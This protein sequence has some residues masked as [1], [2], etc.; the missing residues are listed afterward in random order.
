MSIACAIIS[1]ILLIPLLQLGEINLPGNDF[2]REAF[3]MEDGKY[4]TFSVGDASILLSVVS[5]NSRAVI[6]LQGDIRLTH[7]LTIASGKHIIVNGN[8]H[9]I[10]EYHHPIASETVVNGMR[11]ADY[12]E[13]ID[14]K[15]A[16]TTPDGTTL[17]L[18][19]SKVFQATGWADIY[20]ESHNGQA[21]QVPHGVTCGADKPAADQDNVFLHLSIWYKRYPLLLTA[22]SSTKLSFDPTGV[23]ADG[24]ITNPDSRSRFT[25]RPYYYLSNYG[26]SPDAVTIKNHKLYFPPQYPAVA[27]CTL[28]QIVSVAAGGQ[29]ELNDV[30]LS[31]GRNYTIVNRGQLRMNGCTL[32]NPIARGIYSAGRLFLERSAFCDIRQHAVMADYESPAY[33]PYADITSCSFQRIGLYGSDASAIKTT[34]KS[35]IARNDFTDVQYASIC[36][37]RTY[38]MTADKVDACHTLAEHNRIQY[39][40]WWKGLRRQLALQDGGAIY[41]ATN[42]RQAVVRYNTIVGAGSSF[43]ETGAYYRGIFC[44]D[45]AYNMQIY[46][47]VIAH[48]EQGTDCYDIDSRDCIA[49]RRNNVP[50]GPNPRNTNNYICYNLCTGL[51][52]M[53]ELGSTSQD[54]YVP[55][56]S[57]TFH[58]NIIIGSA[59]GINRRD[60]H[61]INSSRHVYSKQV[62]AECQP[63]VV[64]QTGFIDSLGHIISN[65]NYTKSLGIGE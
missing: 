43:H 12:P 17:T 50:P 16:F 38:A 34:V 9:K 5:S 1:R 11:Q 62:K 60:G 35:Y 21:Y 44:D 31:G 33:Q 8:G 51:L 24:V 58:K 32:S 25:R 4:P 20:P 3:H 42:N 13:P 36:M 57:C 56:S 10:Y 23:L 18:A 64:D 27:S 59:S 49:D 22:Q 45:G 28:A 61:V 52:K 53:Q 40:P 46:C 19:K 37:G 54:Q 39:T 6:Q 29:L 7:Q 47:N 55:D 48:T 65:Y 15:T 2:E 30:S 14:E 41:I 63:I 26:F